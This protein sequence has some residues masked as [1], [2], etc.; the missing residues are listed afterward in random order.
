MTTQ[1]G[2]FKRAQR[3]QARLRLGLSAVSGGGKTMGALR[4]A[5]GIVQSLIDT[6]Q[7]QGGIEGK[8]AL[9]DTERKSASLY[10]HVVP[11]DT[12]E[13][14]PPYSVDRYQQAI[15]AAE[16][17]GYVVCIIDQISHAWAGPGGQL[18]WIDTLKAGAKN[19]ISP[20]A[21]VTPVQQEFYDRMLRSPMHLIVTM[22]AKTEWVIED[23]VG[24]G[25]RVRKVPRKIGLQPVQREGIEYEFTTMLDI[26]LD[27]HM[28]TASKDRTSLFMDRSTRLDE[29]CGRKLAEWLVSGVSAPAPEPKPEPRQEGGGSHD[30]GGGQEARAKLMQQLADGVEDYQLSF[31]TCSTLPDLAAQFD[32]AQKFARGFSK[33]LG[34]EIV[35]PHLAALVKSKDVRKEALQRQN[36]PASTFLIDSQGREIARVDRALHPK[37][38]WTDPSGK[39]YEVGALATESEQAKVYYA[40]PKPPRDLLEEKISAEEAA[41]LEELGK[42]AGLTATEILDAAGVKDLADLP[43]SQLSVAAELVNNAGKA[44]AAAGAPKRRRAAAGARA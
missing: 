13:L 32:K 27:T 5:K 18:E 30:A 6:G 11:F 33:D 19:A 41:T 39:E 7:V 22:R 20:W 15:D 4:L 17:A 42:D 9:I 44:K 14:E 43:K 21:K 23:V 25:G 31:T 8:I 3:V 16:R 1:I 12:L 34:G 35:Q 29:D 37:D 26:D 24:E 38:I 36:A 2:T 40:V 10:A 28:A